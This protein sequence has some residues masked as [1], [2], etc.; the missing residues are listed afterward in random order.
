MKKVNLNID[1]DKK[2][3]GKDTIPV[4][5]AINIIMNGINRAINEPDSSGRATKSVGMDIQRQVA[6]IIRVLDSHI[7]GIVELDDADYDF[8]YRKLHKDKLFPVG[9]DISP[10]LEQIENKFDEAK[11]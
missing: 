11:K 3:F 2:V 1:I 6:R 8:I 4:D 7:D 5:I 9:R 10:I